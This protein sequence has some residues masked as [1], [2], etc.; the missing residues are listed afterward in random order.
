MGGFVPKDKYAADVN[1]SPRQNQR[2]LWTP[3]Q[4]LETRAIT[5]HRGRYLSWTPG[6]AV[7]AVAKKIGPSEQ[8]LIDFEPKTGLVTIGVNSGIFQ[9]YLRVIIP[10]K[11]TDTPEAEIDVNGYNYYHGAIFWRIII[12]PDYTLSFK[13]IDN[14][15]LSSDHGLI[16]ARHS[17]N[18]DIGPRDK[19]IIVPAR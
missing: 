4:N 13:S 15:Y 5:N 11:I 9:R 6:G 18:N 16:I 8:W 7:T 12:H 10:N 17:D 3:Y 2:F 1:W 19:F 14:R